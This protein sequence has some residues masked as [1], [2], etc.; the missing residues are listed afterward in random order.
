[1]NHCLCSECGNTHTK[2]DRISIE[3]FNELKKA[4]AQMDGY[5]MNKNYVIVQQIIEIE[6]QD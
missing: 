4:G 6:T 5:P 3:R 1:L 2:H